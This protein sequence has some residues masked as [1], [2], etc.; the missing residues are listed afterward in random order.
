MDALGVG[1]DVRFS[2][3]ALSPKEY[4]L[5]HGIKTKSCMKAR[6]EVYFIHEI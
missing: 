2:Y 5:R 6:C 4:G 1:K 3:L